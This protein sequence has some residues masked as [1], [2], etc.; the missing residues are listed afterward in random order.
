MIAIVLKLIARR[1][2]AAVPILLIVSA[3]LF[4]MLRLLPVDPAAM[5]LPP[6]A[7]IAEI[8]AKRREMGLDQPLPQQYLIWL[9]DALH[10]DFGRSIALRRDAGELVAAT[11]PATIQLAACAMVI[12]AILGLG[13]GLAAVPPARHAVRAGGGPR[14][15]RAAVDSGISLGTDPAVRVRRDAAMA[16][17]HRTG[18]AGTA[19]AAHH[20]L[21][22][23]RFAAGRPLRRVLERVPASDP[24]RRRA[25]ARVLADHHAGAALEPVRRLS[26]KTTS[27]RRGCAACPSGISCSATRSRTPSL[28]TLTLAGVQFGILFCGTLLV[29]VIYSYP[30]MGNLMVD[31]VRNADLPLIQA[32]GLTYCIV[33]LLINTVGRQSLRRAQPETAGAL[34]ASAMSRSLRSPRVLIALGMIL[35]IAFCAVFAGWIAPHDPG[36]QNL[37]AILQPPAWADGGDL[38]YPLGTDSLGRCVLSR[39]IYGARTAMLVA[40][41]A[42]LGAMIIGTDPGAHL[43]LFRRRRGLADRPRWSMSGCRFRR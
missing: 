38:T 12:A 13:G 7:T 29:E 33:V 26:W 17:V 2:L 8:E 24:A 40:L 6:N 20:R 25:R 14:L 36:D 42:S 5:S 18:L 9:A 34:M 19:A 10:G 27:I 43:R 37:L 31:A 23:A 16:A 15:D 4:C 11:L 35:C 3:L 41:F 21:S 39:L 32:I 22:V 1:L 30:G 28:P